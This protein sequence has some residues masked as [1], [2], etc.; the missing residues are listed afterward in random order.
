MSEN[1]LNLAAVGS[2]SLVKRILRTLDVQE[3]AARLHTDARDFLVKEKLRAIRHFVNAS[4]RKTLLHWK[5]QAK[6]RTAHCNVHKLKVL[7][8]KLLRDKKA[9]EGAISRV[10]KIE[11]KSVKASLTDMSEA[12]PDGRAESKI[13]MP[14]DPSDKELK[15]PERLRTRTPMQEIKDHQRTPCRQPMQESRDLQSKQTPRRTS[16]VADQE[17]QQPRGR[18]TTRRGREPKEAACRA[19][20]VPVKRED[21]LFNKIRADLTEKAKAKGPAKEEAAGV[22]LY[23]RAVEIESRRE[24]LKR[25]YEP[26]FSFAPRLAT[27]TEKWLNHRAS[28]DCKP[29]SSTEEVAVVSSVAIMSLNKLQPMQDLETPKNSM[30][31]CSTGRG[32]PPIARLNDTQNSSK[33]SF[34]DLTGESCNKENSRYTEVDQSI[35][36]ITFDV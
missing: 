24:Q 2:F 25:T 14:K 11:I 29:T 10:P 27:N 7:A 30:S 15:Q 1:L 12:K 33:F 35:L 6:L 36:E 34:L 20:S 21:N 13:P 19:S 23:N 5:F 3:S 31:I 22:R 16:R 26:E 28:K 17:N 4:V 8:S 32:R 9:T 18:E